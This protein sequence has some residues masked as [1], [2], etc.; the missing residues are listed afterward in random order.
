MVVWINGAFGVGKTSVAQALRTQLPDARIFDP[1]LIGFVLRRLLRP[2]D[3]QD[4]RSWRVLTR[5]VAAAASRWADPLIVPM[6]ICRAEYF[7]EIVGGL[8]RQRIAVRHF[9]LTAPRA[10]V[11]KRLADRGD[12]GSW[13]A[14]QLDRCV[15][16]LADPTFG[17][18]IETDGRS[19]H[20]VA[21][22]IRTRSG[23][24]GPHTPER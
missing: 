19:P 22:D 16:A 10:T 14:A 12:A 21:T 8:R 6:S 7:D 2:R 24:A 1:E 5:L 23:I 18:H 17:E 4:L 13:A 3:Y 20:E 15:G 9:T 11:L